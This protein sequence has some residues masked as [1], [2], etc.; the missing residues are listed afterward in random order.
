MVLRECTGRSE[1]S[2]DNKGSRNNYFATLVTPY[3]VW[4]SGNYNSTIMNFYIRPN[5]FFSIVYSIYKYVFT[6][7]VISAVL[8]Y[9]T[10]EIIR[11]VWNSPVQFCHIP[12][13]AYPI[14]S[15]QERL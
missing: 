12:E 8:C 13:H 5:Q 7:I 1:T 10:E 4:D 11:V 14:L 9:R 15:R 3:S 6:Y 2:P